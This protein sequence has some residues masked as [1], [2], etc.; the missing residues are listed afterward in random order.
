[1]RSI[2]LLCVC[3]AREN[4]S[5]PRR[6]DCVTHRAAPSKETRMLRTLQLSLFVLPLVAAACSGTSTVGNINPES[7][8]MHDVLLVGNSAAGTVSFID[9]HSYQNLGTINIIPDLQQRLA[10]ING[11]IIHAIAYSL[12]KSREQI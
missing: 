5:G 11:N 3:R 2:L 10:D 12:I 4:T 6:L 8:A 9:G 1:M 7:T